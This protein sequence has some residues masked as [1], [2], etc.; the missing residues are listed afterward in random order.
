MGGCGHCSGD[1]GGCTGCSGCGGQMELSRGEINMLLVLGQIPFLPVA[2]KMGDDVPVYLEDTECPAEEYSL[3]LQCLEKRGLISIDYDLPL[4]GF[5]GKTYEG[6]PVRGS[7][8]LT[9]R[10]QQVVELLEM[11]GIG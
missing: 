4:K 3:I 6:Y 8:A 1:C 7:F 2:R 10:G 11:Q 9:A 5:S